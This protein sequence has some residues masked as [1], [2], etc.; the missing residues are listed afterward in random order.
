ME[1]RP[2]RR[3]ELAIA[4]ALAVALFCLLAL[5]AAAQDARITQHASRSSTKPIK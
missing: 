3:V 2:A 4:I 1:M 5:G